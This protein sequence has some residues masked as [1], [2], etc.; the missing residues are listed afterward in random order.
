[1]QLTVENISQPENSPSKLELSIVADLQ[2]SPIRARKLVNI[3]LM[4]Y[5]GDMLH[6]DIPDELIARD[7]DVFW[8]VPVILS[9]GRAGRIGVV[10]RIDVHTETGELQLSDSL[11]TEILEN[12]HRLVAR[13][14]PE[15]IA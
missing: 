11:V 13:A 10:G 6:G 12:A 2:I 7:K 14:T 9:G 15:P 3:Y 5:V 1:M 4:N 8:R